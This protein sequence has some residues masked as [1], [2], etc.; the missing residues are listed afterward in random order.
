MDLVL[1][2]FLR[3]RSGQRLN[4]AVVKDSLNVPSV[5]DCE[6][7]CLRSR[8]FTCRIFSYRYGPAVIGGPL[9][10]CQLSDWPFV[11][12]DSR[13]DLVEDVGYE[14]YERGSYGHGCEVDRRPPRPPPYIPPV[15]TDR[16]P[17]PR[18]PQGPNK[19]TDELCYVG[20]GGP[21]RLLPSSIRS[22]LR[23]PTEQDC[24]TECSRARDTFLFYCS[25]ISFRSDSVRHHDG[26]PNCLLSDIDQRDLRPGLDYVHQ[27]NHWMFAW[28]SLDP[29]CDPHDNPQTIGHYQDHFQDHLIPGP[30]GPEVWQRF[31]VSGRPCRYGTF[32][33]ENREAGFW[34]C[35]LEGG[36]AGSFDYCC[37]PGHQ[38]GY[39]EGF[40]YPW[41][42]VGSAARDQWRPCSDRYFPYRG[43]THG[44]PQ[45]F[46]PRIPEGPNG[47]HHGSNGPY[48]GP[49]GP[50]E[51]PNGPRGPHGDPYGPPRY[52]PV[53]YLHAEGPP[54]STVI[55][56]GDKQ[57]ALLLTKYDSQEGFDNYIDVNRYNYGKKMILF[58]P[59]K[60]NNTGVMNGSRFNSTPNHDLERMDM[61]TDGSK[62]NQDSNKDKVLFEIVDEKDD[63]SSS[64]INNGG[65]DESVDLSLKA[66]DNR[67][68][69]INKLQP[70]LVR[71]DA[72]KNKRPEV[73]ER[74]VPKVWSWRDND[75]DDQ[76]PG[77]VEFRRKTIPRMAFVTATREVQ[78]PK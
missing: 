43:H 45:S 36:D 38:C 10:N 30:G 53:A 33:A 1:E 41:C 16:V 47:P 56:P 42:Y 2:C 54:N 37:R 73:M 71:N 75:S 52:W 19:P 68:A 63:L 7:E 26:G 3:V 74:S 49:N 9:D 23:V 6:L 12:L 76:L 31:T 17:P 58:S 55:S 62:T 61:K 50:H 32:C 69:T 59:S 18:P 57:P 78:S 22:S 64:E 25:A 5:V 27:E 51:G 20:Y 65:G 29:R 67:H 15:N 60:K 13:R 14:L 40:N 34:S 70:R 21:A 77:P 39:S 48:Q 66:S 44:G 11:E 24:K 4:Q 28:N 72:D 46:P 35:E 8:F